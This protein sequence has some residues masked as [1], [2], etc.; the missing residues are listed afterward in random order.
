MTQQNQNYYSPAA[1]NITLTQE[2][3]ANIHWAEV[4]S[5]S[6]SHKN[7]LNEPMILDDDLNENKEVCVLC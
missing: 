1:Q 5:S 4:E 6:N 7:D 2:V 3:N